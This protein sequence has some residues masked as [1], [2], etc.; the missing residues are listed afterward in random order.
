MSSVKSI[1]SLILVLFR[2]TKSLNGFLYNSYY[3]VERNKC[4]S[5]RSFCKNN[6]LSKTLTISNAS[7]V[8]LHDRQ[9]NSPSSTV[10][11]K[12]VD[13]SEGVTVGD[14]RGATLL[15][16]DVAISRGSNRL[17]S[18][19]NLRVE[20]KERWG[21]VGSNGSG[22]STLLGAIMGTVRVDEGVAMVAPKVR[23]GYLKQTAVAGSR[24]TVAEEA[25]SGMQEL[26]EAKRAMEEVQRIIENGDYSSEVLK[27]LDLAMERYESAGGYTQEQV[28]DSVLAG[29][30]FTS[31]DSNRHCSDF[32]GGWQMRIALAKLLLSQPSLLLLG[33]K[34]TPRG[35]H[36]Q[37]R[38]FWEN[39]H[40][41]TIVSACFQY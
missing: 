4:F 10:T 31:E 27:R 6:R 29:L 33:E 8:Q 20:Q 26:M 34:N 2:N 19:V 11:R 32:S 36:S 35:F 30:G 17:L 9:P 23:V 37:L 40:T 16:Q 21:I 3:P 38:E 39:K 13:S 15:L 14:T 24:R 1:L 25:A 41:H 5:Q 28:V 7:K 22:K 18:N 12:P